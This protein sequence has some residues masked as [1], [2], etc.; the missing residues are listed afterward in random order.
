MTYESK[1]Q[2]VRALVGAYNQDAAEN[3]AVDFDRF[4]TELKATRGRE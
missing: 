1:L 3:R 2:R 4:E